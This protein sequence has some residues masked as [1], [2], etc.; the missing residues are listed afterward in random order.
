MQCLSDASRDNKWI[1]IL[2]SS[3]INTS[4]NSNVENPLYARSRLCYRRYSNRFEKIWI[5]LCLQDPAICISKVLSHYEFVNRK[6]YSCISD[7]K[8]ANNNLWCG[9]TVAWFEPGIWWTVIF[10]TLSTFHI[11]H[12]IHA[13]PRF[14]PKTSVILKRKC[15]EKSSKIPNITLGL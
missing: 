13:H 6:T 7:N 11:Y 2:T 9:C 1:I 12:I 8:F 5:A 4:I 15:K 14:W 3:D 10:W